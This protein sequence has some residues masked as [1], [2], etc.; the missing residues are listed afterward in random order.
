[1]SEERPNTR[2]RP[3][4]EPCLNCGDP[5]PGRYC[6]TCGQRKVEVLV[7]IRGLLADVLEDQLVLNRALPR[8]LGALLF[9]P[10]FL[11][12]EYVRGRIV[13]YIAP[14][15]L[16]LVSSVV[17]FLLMSFIGIRGVDVDINAT[18]DDV[19]GADVN[20]ALDSA[21]AALRA[22]QQTLQDLDSASAGDSAR[23]A[24][25][26]ARMSQVV[27]SLEAMSDTA[28]LRD[29]AGAPDLGLDADSALPQGARQP[30]ARNIRFD[31]SSGLFRAALERKLGQVG[32]L[33]LRDAV[34]ELLRDL[35]EYAP[36]MVF[37]LLPLFALILKLLY[38]RRGRYYAEH[39]VFALHAHAFIFAMFTLMLILPWSLEFLF[40]IWIEVYLWLALRRV[41]QQGWVRTT[42]KWWALGAVYSLFL[43]LG[44]VGL[45]V[46]TLLLT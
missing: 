26:Q 41:Y 15:R 33:P 10:G 27:A 28:A 38:I 4:G 19:P 39:F 21:I 29:T 42:L 34:R 5:T 18:G 7:S 35:L 9:R 22:E 23:A 36:H 14:F 6:P 3:P 30:W 44:A 40:V 31:G 20:V 1:M 16:Y 37:L 8:T 11:T 46:A 17:F 32:H 13:R 2:W 45:A 24:A 25:L 43:L 12:A